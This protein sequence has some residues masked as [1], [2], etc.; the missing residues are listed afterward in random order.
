MR[1]LRRTGVAAAVLAG[2]LVLAACGGGG[3]DAPTDPEE[4]DTGA[5][6]GGEEAGSDDPIHA[7]VFGGIG[8]EGILR[9]NATTSV[10]AAT[11]SAAAVND[12]GGIDGREVKLTVVDD[13]ADP[14]VAVTKLR[15]L[16]AGDDRPDVVMN[17]G[18]ST[19][20]EALTPILTEEE[21]LSFN[22]GPTETTGDPAVS[23]YNFDLSPS[24]DDYLGSFVAEVLDRG[25]ES[26]AVLHDSTPY[27]EL[28]GTSAAE[29]IADVGV[30][31]TGIEVYDG[32]SLDMTA[33]LDK[34]MSGDPEAL[35]LDSY[36]ASLGYILEG[37]EKLG[38]DLP[39]MG[40][41]S[42]S[43]TGL[44]AKEAPEGV[45]GTDRVKNLTMQ[46]FVSTK[47]DPED[48]RVNEAVERFVEAGDI[49]SSLILGYNYDALLLYRAA[50]E[51]AGSTD[52]ADVAAALTDPA[53]QEAAGTAML[54]L[55]SFTEESHTPHAAPEEYLFIE[56]SELVNGQFQ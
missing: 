14:T 28:F 53:V 54:R 42:V 32:N 20:A 3:A 30:E 24:V 55:F 15:E 51:S 16:L 12:T 19:I 21:I 33:Q 48:D 2:S 11:A 13:T 4:T 29:Q 47:Y 45:L 31:I 35:I 39:I 9:D 49:P 6:E 26:V 38:W 27:G 7:V 1:K 18:P 22:I 56:P 46:V 40:N 34:L 17:S 52:A 25:Y 50:V 43:A 5:A 8:A 10:T 37:I 36:G 44:V 23:P 41:T